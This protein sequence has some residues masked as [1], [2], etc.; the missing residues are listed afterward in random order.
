MWTPE[1]EKS[2]ELRSRYDRKR[3]DPVRRIM[4]IATLAA[5]GL[6]IASILRTPAERYDVDLGG[7]AE[8]SHD[9]LFLG[10]TT[11]LPDGA[12]LEYRLMH[13]SGRQIR[14][15][16]TVEREQF[17]A[18]VPLSDLMELRTDGADSLA[19]EDLELQVVFEIVMDDGP[20]E[21]EIVAQFGGSGDRLGGEHVEQVPFGE[22]LRV[23]IPVV[24]QR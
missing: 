21:L 11:N 6:L 12:I 19:V 23:S 15:R 24:D 17:D 1:Q 4:V 8:L 10:G 9:G 13:A 7:R 20:Q 3:A 2:D 16:T 5:V 14:G 18:S 22:R